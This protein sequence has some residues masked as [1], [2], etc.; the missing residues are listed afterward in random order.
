MP[1]MKQF[2][3]IY[4]YVWHGERLYAKYERY[5]HTPRK[6]NL[7]KYQCLIIVACASNRIVF[8]SDWLSYDRM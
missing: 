8:F 6:N 5:Q 4:L 1:D 7:S 2:A 3:Y